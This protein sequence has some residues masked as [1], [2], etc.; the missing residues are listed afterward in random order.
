[1]DKCACVCIQWD[2][3]VAMSTPDDQI[4]ASKY[5]ILQ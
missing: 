4:L 3:P 5:I 1:M 2:G